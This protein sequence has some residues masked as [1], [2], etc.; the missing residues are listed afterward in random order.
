MAVALFAV[1]ASS[2]AFLYWRGWRPSEG[3]DFLKRQLPEKHIVEEKPAPIAV[4]G[5]R[6]GRIEETLYSLAR[7]IDREG[8]ASFQAAEDLRQQLARLAKA[9]DAV[10]EGCNRLT[11]VASKVSYWADKNLVSLPN[12]LAE[13]FSDSLGQ[14]QKQQ[15]CLLREV[16]DRL[17]RD[18]HGPRQDIALLSKPSAAGNPTHSDRHLTP[19]EVSSELLTAL[20]KEGRNSPAARVDGL[21]RWMAQKAP[22]LEVRVL[23]AA[24]DLWLL[25]VIAEISSERGLV[26][27]ALDTTHG[28]GELFDW[29]ECQNY[30]GTTTLRSS[31]ILEP[32]Q[33]QRNGLGRW[34]PHR[35][36]V[37]K[38]ETRTR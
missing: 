3:H 35:K 24:D 13:A 15:E 33:A 25:A 38:R 27:P 20:D 12:I 32:G 30:D 2:G 9:L 1:V 36:G 28:P 16:S 17:T 10:N 29:F 22:N 4:S 7:V 8:L 6:L 21:Q 31:D 11:E 34:I 26:L 18:A 5:D 14:W 37:I 23:K 19:P